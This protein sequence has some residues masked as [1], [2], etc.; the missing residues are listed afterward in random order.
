MPRKRG[1]HSQETQERISA[2]VLGV[3]HTEQ[4][5]RNMSEAQRIRAEELR[6]SNRTQE[7]WLYN[8]ELRRPTLHRLHAEQLCEIPVTPGASTP[9]GKSPAREL[10]YRCT[11]TGTVRRWGCE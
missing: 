11:E 6:M 2:G 10:L 7:A 3:K 4:A 5:R 9:G 8:E 1:P